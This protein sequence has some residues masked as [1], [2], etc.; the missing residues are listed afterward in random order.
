[1]RMCQIPVNFT[2][3]LVYGDCLYNLKLLSSILTRQH[4]SNMLLI[5]VINAE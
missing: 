4:L 5:L 2:Y 1:M 3:F